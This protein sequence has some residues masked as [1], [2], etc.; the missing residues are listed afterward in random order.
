MDKEETMETM[1]I[2]FPGGKQVDAQYKGFTHHSDQPK[3]EGGAGSAP[4]PYDLFLASLGTCAGIYVLSFCRER[5]IDTTGLGLQ[6]EAE[7]NE[8]TR[9]F[10]MVRLRIRLP[11]AFPRKY[12]KALQKTAGLCTVKR[13][14]AKPPDF[15][16][17]VDETDTSE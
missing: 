15:E 13:S 7:K 4:E 2:H 6:L 8:K 16:I 14:L 5:G 11:A 1:D 10:A 17:L 9:L 3:E 12:I